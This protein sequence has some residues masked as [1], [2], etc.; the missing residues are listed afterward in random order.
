MSTHNLCSNGSGQKSWYLQTSIWGG[1][2]GGVPGPTRTL[3]TG[4]S[5]PSSRITR[6]HSRLPKSFPFNRCGEERRGICCFKKCGLKTSIAEINLSNLHHLAGK[7]T[8]GHVNKEQDPDQHDIQYPHP[9]NSDSLHCWKNTRNHPWDV[10]FIAYD[11][12]LRIFVI[13]FI[14]I[15][16]FYFYTKFFHYFRLK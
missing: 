8:V 7:M 5:S 15:R 14:W 11:V 2:G 16:I 13:F 10:S 6:K 3:C 4:T 1:S 12:R 9:N